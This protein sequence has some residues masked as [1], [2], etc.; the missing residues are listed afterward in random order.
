MVY[1]FVFD[2]FHQCLTSFL[3]TG[4]LPPLDFSV[5]QWYPT[6]CRFIPGY[7]VLFVAVVNAMLS[8]I[9]L[10]FLLLF[11]YGNGTDTKANTDK[12]NSAESP[13]I[14][15]CTYGHLCMIPPI[16]MKI[17]IN[18]W[19]LIKHS[20]CTAKGNYKQGEKTTLRMRE[21]NSKSNN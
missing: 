16:V 15:P 8:L 21:N 5:A 10:P 18:K 3:H 7:F 17:K 12:P 6:P 9:S 19:D 13:E 20:F 1:A 14:N 11:V 4:L 2:F